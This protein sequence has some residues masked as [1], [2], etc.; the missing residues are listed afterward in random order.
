KANSSCY[1]HHHRHTLG[2]TVILSIALATGF[3]KDVR[4]QQAGKA[5]SLVVDDPRPILKAIELLELRH[6]WLITYED[7]PYVHEND[8]V[9]QT[10]PEYRATGRRALIPRGGKISISETLPSNA[11]AV[12]Q[13]VLD[14]HAFRANPG[15]F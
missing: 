11:A 7:A 10:S 12:T 15:R 9:D 1:C 6:G 14:D 2:A 4:A 13:M 5:L 3:D 8:V